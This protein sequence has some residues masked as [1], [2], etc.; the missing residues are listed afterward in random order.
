MDD[1]EFSEP[2][3]LKQYAH[4]KGMALAMP[5][6]RKLLGLSEYGKLPDTGIGRALQRIIEHNS[7]DDVREGRTYQHETLE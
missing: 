7:Q 2:G 4:L 3:I 5:V 6:I 1:Y